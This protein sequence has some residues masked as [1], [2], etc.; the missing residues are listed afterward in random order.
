MSI[1]LILLEDVKD[2]GKVGDQVHVAEGYAR[3]YLFPR[4]LAT[5][6][7]PVALKQIE[8]KKL[9]LQKEHEERLAVANAMAEKI[10]KLQLTISAKAGDDDKLFGSV[11]AANIAEALAAQG[12]EVEKG[13]VQLAEPIHALG[14]FEVEVRLH[15][16]V[17]ATA[18]LTVVRD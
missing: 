11:T 8:A 5:L 10:A 4:K 6:I 16:E 9:K 17:T 1:Q 18:K 7:T 2:L 15:A 12:I 13:A 14:S 3:N